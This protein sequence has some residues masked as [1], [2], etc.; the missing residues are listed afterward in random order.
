MPSRRSLLA[1]AVIV[2]GAGCSTSSESDV[3]P[4][5]HVPDDWHAE[6][7]RGLADPFTMSASKLS[8]YPQSDCPSLAAESAAKLL[9]D[10]LGNPDNLSG[11]EMSLEV[12]GHD[13]AIV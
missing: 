6:P 11:G 12:D 1:A 5:E 4:A 10:R 9:E 2:V 7:E 3:D 13:R 8:Q